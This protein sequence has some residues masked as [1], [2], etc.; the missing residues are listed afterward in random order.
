MEAQQKGT[1][2]APHKF[3][4]PAYGQQSLCFAMLTAGSMKIGHF[5]FLENVN[6]NHKQ[7]LLQVP[8]KFEHYSLLNKMPASQPELVL[9]VLLLLET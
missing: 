2:F 5:V 7:N 6:E 9:G 8:E 4:Y 1:K 3:L